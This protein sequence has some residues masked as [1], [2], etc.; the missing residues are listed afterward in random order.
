MKN[1]YDRVD[2]YR[3]GETIYPIVTDSILKNLVIPDVILTPDSLKNFQFRKTFMGGYLHINNNT[4][5][6]SYND[7]TTKVTTDYVSV[8]PT[9][10][11]DAANPDGYI[12]T[13]N[14]IVYPLIDRVPMPASLTL[15]GYLTKNRSTTNS[16]FYKILFNTNVNSDLIP[17]DTKASP[18]IVADKNDKGNI[19]DPNEKLWAMLISEGNDPQE[20]YTVFY[21]TDAALKAYA[22][23]CNVKTTNLPTNSY[24]GGNQNWAKIARQ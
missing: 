14:G 11:R 13:E 21:P 23:A 1:D 20:I 5:L 15:S 6:F 19:T 10:P 3:N 24:D 7:P 17:E 8:L 4:I 18:A 22:A 2:L 9:V 16:N 12:M